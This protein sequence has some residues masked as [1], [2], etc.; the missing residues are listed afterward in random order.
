M[1]IKKT[2]NQQDIANVFK[3]GQSN[4]LDS[5]L[6]HT[7]K[8]NKITCSGALTKGNWNQRALFCSHLRGVDVGCTTCVSCPSS[9]SPAICCK[10]G[11]QAGSGEGPQARLAW[12]MVHAF[13]PEDEAYRISKDL[14]PASLM[15]QCW[16]T[17]KTETKGYIPKSFP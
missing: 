15:L 1:V 16:K 3:K 17:C 4:L 12:Y 7:K 6:P 2:Q 14:W 10:A 9:E 13:L 8:D 11:H 5:S